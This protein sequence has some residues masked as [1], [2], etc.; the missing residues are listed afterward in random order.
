MTVF[1][2]L[3]LAGSL[4]AQETTITTDGPP[5]PGKGRH[6]RVMTREMGK[7]WENQETVQKLQLSDSQVAQLN[8][9][10]YDH[11]LKLI[12]YGA[13]MAKEDL[14][15]QNLLDA[16]QPNE[17]QVSSQVDQVLAARGKLEREYTMMNLD[18]RKVISVEQWKQLKTI[19]GGAGMP[20]ENVLF[21][22]RFDGGGGMGMHVDGS[23][24]LPPPPPPPGSLD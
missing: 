11:K 13:S 8:Q 5:P 17:S 15:L 22:K 1:G 9:V 20:G 24:P 2:L 7:W 3:L 18:L 16:D 4:L 12:D 6:V 21:Y 10:F 23:G 19:R 14:K